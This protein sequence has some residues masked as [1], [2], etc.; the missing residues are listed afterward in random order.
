MR[1]AAATGA[2][3]VKISGGNGKNHE[4][5]RRDTANGHFRGR[6]IDNTAARPKYSEG[7]D[8]APASARSRNRPF[9]AQ[10]FFT[11]NSPIVSAAAVYGGRAFC[12][13]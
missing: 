8:A 4:T 5:M 13:R 3:F 11:K 6:P 1:H 10:S 9:M 12:N 2:D 7:N